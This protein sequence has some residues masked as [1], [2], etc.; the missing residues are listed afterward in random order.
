MHVR[1]GGAIEWRPIKHTPKYGHAFICM[2][3]GS[4]HGDWGR[5]HGDCEGAWGLGGCMGTVRVHG[6]CEGAWGL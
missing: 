1:E 6:D 5:V 4:V 2:G 3:T